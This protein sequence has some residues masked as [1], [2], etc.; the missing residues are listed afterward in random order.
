MV[1]LWEKQKKQKFKKKKLIYIED[2]MESVYEANVI[3]SFT[4]ED[5]TILTELESKKYLLKVGEE[6]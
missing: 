5:K 1:V 6:T 3:G 2:N 4:F